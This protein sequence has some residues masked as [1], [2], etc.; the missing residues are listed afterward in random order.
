MR[1]GST[2][3]HARSQ[4]PAWERTVFEALP[5]GSSVP[6]TPLPA[7]PAIHLVPRQSR[8]AWEPDS[9]DQRGVS[10]FL[11]FQ[12]NDRVGGIEQLLHRDTCKCCFRRGV[13]TV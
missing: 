9:G 3:A 1:E 6:M 13:N 4:A 5:L 10:S 11:F 8:R 7:E 2:Y 12:R